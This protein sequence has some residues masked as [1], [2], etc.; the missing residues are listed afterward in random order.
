MKIQATIDFQGKLEKS[1]KAIIQYNPYKRRELYFVPRTGK[2]Y[3]V[4]PKNKRMLYLAGDLDL[5]GELFINNRFVKDTPRNRSKLNCS[6]KIKNPLMNRWI[7]DTPLNRKKVL[8]SQANDL[9]KQIIEYKAA[10]AIKN[11]F[12][13]Q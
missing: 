5:Q 4:S 1:Q 10:K 12:I 8:K 13:N 9:S 7:K 3:V 2:S 11:F 6:N